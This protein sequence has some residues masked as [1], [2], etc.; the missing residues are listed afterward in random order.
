MFLPAGIRA[1]AGGEAPVRT[2]VADQLS[3][4]SPEGFQLQEVSV[5]KGGDAE[6]SIETVT[7]TYLGPGVRNEITH[8]SFATEQSAESFLETLEKDSCSVRL[9]AVCVTRVGRAVLTAASAST[10]PHPM[11]E[12][13]ERAMLLLE[14]AVAR[15]AA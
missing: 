9:R 4:D 12:V 11:P 10:C 2:S 14:F 13:R 3:A 1:A 7:A 8:I 5:S 6:G 15:L